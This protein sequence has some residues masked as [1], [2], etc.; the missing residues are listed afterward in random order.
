MK[1]ISFAPAQALAVHDFSGPLSRQEVLNFAETRALIDAGPASFTEEQWDDL[2]QGQALN[3][4]LSTPEAYRRMDSPQEDHVKFLRELVHSG[5][6]PEKDLP[7]TTVSTLTP[8]LRSLR[9]KELSASVELATTMAFILRIGAMSSRSIARAT[10]LSYNT[11]LRHAQ[12]LADEEKVDGLVREYH[13]ISAESEEEPQIE[14]E[15]EDEGTDDPDSQ[16][17]S[18]ARVASLAYIRL[19]EISDLEGSFIATETAFVDTFLWVFD[20]DPRTAAEVLTSIFRDVFPLGTR[21][22]AAWE[23]IKDGMVMAARG[24][25]RARL[26]QALWLIRNDPDNSGTLEASQ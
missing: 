17:R 10:G 9:E 3:I 7:P 24:K 19:A 15:D 8:N 1:N 20:R 23:K 16:V 2:T 21:W 14:V 11:V 6:F 22:S 4:I 18:I 5:V 26:T 12:T 13:L 25:D